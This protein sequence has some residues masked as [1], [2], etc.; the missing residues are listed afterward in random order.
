MINFYDAKSELTNALI[1]FIKACDK[2]DRNMPD[3]LED[4]IADA[5]ES[6]K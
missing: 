4:C 1:D 3:E 5:K 6:L 2:D